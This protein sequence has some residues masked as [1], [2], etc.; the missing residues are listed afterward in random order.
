MQAGLVS[1]DRALS[2]QELRLR[3]LR[4]ARGFDAL[5]V[6]RGDAVALMLRN[7]FPLL[8][9]SLAAG[10]LGAYATPVNF[11]YRAD[12]TAY[13]LKDCGAKALVIHADLIPRIGAALPADIPVLVVPAPPEVRAAHGVPPEQAAVPPGMTGWEDFLAAHAP[14]DRPPQL[15]PASLIYTSGTTGRP[16]GVRR[17]PPTPEQ[18]ALVN[19]M[20]V[21]VFGIDGPVR[22]VMA[23]PLYHTAPNAYGLSVLR[24][25]GLLV[26]QPRFDP[27]DLLRLIERHR[28]THLYLVPT[29]FVRL[30]KLPE[31]VRRRYDVSSLRFVLHAAAPCPPD[32]KRAMIAWWGPVINEFYASTEA[33]TVTFVT[34]EEWLRHPGTVGRPPPDVEVRILDDRKQPVPPGTPGEV[35]SRHRHMP[36][37]T[38]HGQEERRREVE[39]DGLITSGDVG[40]VDADGYLYLC[41]RKRDMVISGG[42]NLYPAEVE[43]ALITMPGVQDCACFGIPDDDLGEAMMAVV[44]AEDG[45]DLTAEAIRAWLRARLAGLKV[46]KRIELRDSLPREDSGKI[47]KR[48]LREPYWRDAGRA[49]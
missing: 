45:V 16:K 40:Y 46:P 30:L 39:H 8:E 34:S 26:L 19:R 33:A 1:G 7:D 36:D 47:F 49:I 37:F 14:W 6:G 35:Y 48:K 15:P 42:V 31:A 43:H 2:L 25:G 5:G 23:A 10:D 21:L 18:Y 4:A 44:Q 24:E 38:Y 9:A 29:M 3:A 17:L 12:E 32:V 27:E 41:D 11:H 20:R 28:I 22:S 13:I